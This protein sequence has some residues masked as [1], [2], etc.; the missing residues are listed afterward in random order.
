MWCKEGREGWGQGGRDGG[1]EE[2]VCFL[3]YI[4]T[5][6]GDAFPKIKHVGRLKSIYEVLYTEI[7]REL[8]MWWH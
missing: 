4:K 3:T 8:N 7:P 6:N 5:Y 2:L 1:R